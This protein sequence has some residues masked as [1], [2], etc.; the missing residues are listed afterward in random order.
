MT[1]KTLHSFVLF[2]MILPTLVLSSLVLVGVKATCDKEIVRPVEWTGG[3]FEWPNLATKSIYR[4]SGR[5]IQ[6]NAIATRAQIY[7][8]DVIVALPRYKAGVP[9]TLAKLSLKHKGC[10]ASLTPFPCWSTQEEGNCNAL[11]SVVDIFADANEILW[12][13]DVGVVN[14]LETP[15]RRCPPKVVAI[16]LRTGKV[17]K[18][19]DLSGLVAQASRLQYIV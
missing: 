2:Q 15:I 16:S 18:T 17:V 12:V 7:K 8:D 4:S 6:K 11:Q 14:T 1:R 9:A 19:L 10:E 5:F 3:N 13:L